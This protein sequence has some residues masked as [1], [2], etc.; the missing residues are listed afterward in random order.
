MP[1]RPGVFRVVW[2][3]A[4]LC[5]E[6]HSRC[7]GMF[8][9]HSECCLLVGMRGRRGRG[10]RSRCYHE[11]VLCLC[12]RACRIPQASDEQRAG[13]ARPDIARSHSLPILDASL[14]LTP[15]DP[16]RSRHDPPAAHHCRKPPLPA[17]AGCGQPVARRCQALPGAALAGR[18]AG[19]NGGRSFGAT[20]ECA[21]ESRAQ[22]VV[23]LSDERGVCST[24][25][26]PPIPP[27]SL[28]PSFPL[29][30][31]SLPWNVICEHRDQ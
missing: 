17:A 22:R 19:E 4:L 26:Q 25:G 27:L 18:T 3:A 23:V 6:L 20:F 21:A 12:P 30:P 29:Y 10:R 15:T 9:I 11:Q 2:L 8:A 31:L 7:R 14:C 28:P 5:T 16:T 24:F 1:R 13:R